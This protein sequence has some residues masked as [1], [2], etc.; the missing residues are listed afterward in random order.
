MKRLRT[1]FLFVGVFCITFSAFPQESKVTNTGTVS[2]ELRRTA[3]RL[4]IPVEQLKKARRTL[5]E[6]TD[7]AKQIKPFPVSQMFNL[8]QGKRG[9]RFLHSGVA[10]RGRQCPRCRDLSA[11]NFNGDVAYAIK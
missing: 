5:Q 10:I 8:T 11:G 7:L 4:H 2:K 3:R 9:Y 1:F 6:A